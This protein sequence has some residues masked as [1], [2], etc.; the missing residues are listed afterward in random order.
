MSDR[1]L[2][3]D[4]QSS[5]SCLS[6]HGVSLTHHKPRAE[7]I[8][9]CVSTQGAALPRSESSAHPKCFGAPPEE[10]TPLHTCVLPSPPSTT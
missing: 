10:L 4:D 8:R 9:G 7:Q 1:W 3:G 2:K 6:D 5:E